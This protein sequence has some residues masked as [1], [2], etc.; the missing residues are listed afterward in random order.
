MKKVYLSLLFSVAFA[1]IYAQ[2]PVQVQTN[3]VTCFGLCN[4]TAMA[5]AS[6]PAPYMYSWAPGNQTTSTITGLC[7]GT[8]TVTV[9]N[10]IGCTASATV[11]ITQPSQLTTTATSIN[12]SCSSCCNGSA[13]VTASGGTPFYTYS[14]TPSGG[15]AQTATGLCPGSYTVCVT[16][17]NGCTSCTSVNVSF[18]TAIA[19]LPGI[20]TISICPVPAAGQIL[21]SF[22]NEDSFEAKILIKNII[23]ETIYMENIGNTK[24]VSR[25][26]DISGLPEGIYFFNI[27]TASGSIAQKII[28]E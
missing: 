2:C 14:W 25:I 21:I 26:L 10:S 16:D 12:A 9:T 19:K 27:E 7:A 11:M 8:Y 6:G 1:A 3:N 20:S 15:I 23:G 5:F 4:G 18:S 13:S 28:K 22:I 17:A 24:Q